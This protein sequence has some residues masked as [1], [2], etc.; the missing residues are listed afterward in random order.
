[1]KP[2][3][4][5]DTDILFTFFAI[6]NEKKNIFIDTG[7][8]GNNDIDAVLNLIKSIESKGQIICMSDFSIL[9]LVCTLNR[10][11]ST[12]K[13]PQIL[14]KIYSMCDVLPL[15]DL[16]IKLAWY[17][18]SRYPLH[19]GDSLHISF[20]LSNDITEIILKEVDFYKVCVNMKNDFQASNFENMERFFT[21]I[22]YA[23]G[24]PQKIS[25]KY[26]NLKNLKITKI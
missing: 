14:T 26:S 9:E 13:I 12:H 15:N 7:T 8:T 6:N 20:C 4:F 23:Q 21:Q 18:A 24:L 3:I 10:L 2:L 5:I 22:T 17:F 25:E 16:M 1:M 19:S 11:K